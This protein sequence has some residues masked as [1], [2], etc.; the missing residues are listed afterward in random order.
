M[1]G[2]RQ[3]TGIVVEGGAGAQAGASR[4]KSHSHLKD[5]GLWCKSTPLYSFF[6]LPLKGFKTRGRHDQSHGLLRMDWKGARRD[7]G[8]HT[9]T[10]SHPQHTQPPNSWQRPVYRK[11][12]EHESPCF[13]STVFLAC[14]SDTT[15]PFILHYS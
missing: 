5:F 10:C 14:F 15:H 8:R 1:T 2:P 11:P 12:Q 4:V 9:L 7:T 13:I 6:F 3:F